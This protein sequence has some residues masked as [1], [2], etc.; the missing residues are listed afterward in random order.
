MCKYKDQCE[1]YDETSNTCNS[2]PESNLNY[3]GKYR[4]F[5][6]ENEK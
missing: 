6:E 3:C 2:C 1:L 4:E 5:E